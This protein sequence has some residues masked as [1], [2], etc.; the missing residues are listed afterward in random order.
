[1]LLGRLGT[2]PI[3]ST[4]A[5]LGAVMTLASC[6][7]GQGKTYTDDD[8]TRALTLTTEDG[9]TSYQTAGGCEISALLPTKAQIKQYKDAGSVVETNPDGTAGVELTDNSDACHAE[10][11]GGLASLD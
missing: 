5:L 7:G 9:G 11:K 2:R 8:L 6:G 10:I 3:V 4:A 1:M